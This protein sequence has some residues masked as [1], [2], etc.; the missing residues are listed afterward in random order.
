MKF[1][2]FEKRLQYNIKPRKTY[3]LPKVLYNYT[4]SLKR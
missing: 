2:S 1:N 4:N 3:T